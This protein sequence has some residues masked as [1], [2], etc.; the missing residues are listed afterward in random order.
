MK[1]DW[2]LKSERLILR[3]PVLE[4]AD[5]IVLGI[6]DWKIASMLATAPFPYTLNDAIEWIENK[7]IGSTEIEHVFAIT[8]ADN[9]DA[10]LVGLMGVHGNEQE[11]GL[12]E[13][14]Y[15][16][17]EPYWGKGYASEAL[18]IL[19]DFAFETFGFVTLVAGNFEDNP[20]SG[21]VLEKT[22]FEPDGVEEAYSRAR[23]G[24]TKSYRWRLTRASRENSQF[25]AR[26]Q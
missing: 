10:G 2:I 12:A 11:K 9:P 16:L 3:T 22:G 15:W 6:S 21:R 4:D 26:A 17:A 23:D 8:L 14:G 5:N 20:G 13:V 7:V 1:K 19:I 18:R 24:L 25:A